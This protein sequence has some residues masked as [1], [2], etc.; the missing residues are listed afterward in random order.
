MTSDLD[1]TDCRQFGPEPEHHGDGLLQRD[2]HVQGGLRLHVG[3][4]QGHARRHQGQGLL[5][6]DL[7]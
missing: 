4:G 6:G 3:R 7:S 2:R 1:E 5:R